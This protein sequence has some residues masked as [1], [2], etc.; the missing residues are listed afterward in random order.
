MDFLST[1][2]KIKRARIYKGLT[3]KQ[4]CKED[5]SISRMSCIENGKVKA[6]RWILKLVADRLELDLEYLL[7]DDI[8]QL[9]NSIEKYSHKDRLEESEANEIR[10]YLEYSMSKEYD[11]T[12]SKLI[13]I[14]FRNYTNLRDFRKAKELLNDYSTIYEKNKN[15]KKKYYEDLAIY[16]MVR[17]KFADAITHYNI[18]LDLILED[19]FQ[20]DQDVYIK[21]TASLAICY[22]RLGQIKSSKEILKK[23]FD[24]DGI[25]LEN[26]ALGE[27]YGLLG[28][29]ALKEN[30]EKE[31]RVNFKKYDRL[32]N[33]T[34]YNWKK[35]NSLMI[36]AFLELENYEEAERLTKES[37]EKVDKTDKIAYIE[38][39][40]LIIDVHN[41]NGCIGKVREY[42]ELSLELSISKNNMFFIE[43]SYYFK[44][45]L[46]KSERND[47]QWEMY[48][49]LATD[50]LLKFGA[51]EEK[52][53]R[54]LEMADLYHYLDDTN[55]AL[56]YLS[57]AIKEM[58][59]LY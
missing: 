23:I 52:R 20:C 51:Y 24:I 39:L 15:N 37:L 55:E 8:T 17:K 48:M 58:D 44:A 29:I 41:K 46:S 56:K 54:Y 19:G 11:D 5:I 7:C 27:V 59:K 28:I 38:M 25:S 14:L 3:L 53:N 47:M 31:F 30:N 12:S 40:L 32:A 21:N 35:I 9:N 42:C 26:K 16:F 10:E 57:F 33:Y 18:L 49:N 13:H 50:L 4:L 6:D 34:S 22:Y 45:E 36:E 1:G 2:E 43:R